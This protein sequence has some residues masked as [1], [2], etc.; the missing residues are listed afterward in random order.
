MENQP[1]KSKISLSKPEDIP[2]ETPDY[3]YDYQPTQQDYN[4]QYSQPTQTYQKESPRR[5]NPDIPKT[6]EQT[7]PLANT[8]HNNSPFQSSN[9]ARNNY[10]NPN[11]TKFCKFCGG[12]IPF[13]AV[14]CTMCGRQVEQLNGGAYQQNNTYIN[15]VNINNNNANLSNKSKTISAVLCA[16][17]FFGI[18]G[19]HRFYTGHI[20]SGILYLCTYGLFGIG[21]IVDLIKIINGSFTDN[22]GRKLKD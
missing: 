21:N 5:L 1:K 2:Q 19:L 6:Y 11:A 9:Y 18:S 4:Q 22:H 7:E 16:L 3:S 12:T 20:L 14:V 17:G 15:N 8:N 13:D 10:S